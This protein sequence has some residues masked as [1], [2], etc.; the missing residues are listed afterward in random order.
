[1]KFLYI[2]VK[3]CNIINSFYLCLQLYYHSFENI[4]FP[5]IGKKLVRSYGGTAMVTGAR[6]VK[7]LDPIGTFTWQIFRAFNPIQF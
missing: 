3:N 7:L 2:L 5:S 1:M 6:W 4:F